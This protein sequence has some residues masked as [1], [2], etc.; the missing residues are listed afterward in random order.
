MV[1]ITHR[2]PCRSHPFGAFQGRCY[3]HDAEKR[4]NALGDQYVLPCRKEF[5]IER[6][7]ADADAIQL[8]IE[9][10]LR[11]PLYPDRVGPK[12]H[13][14]DAHS[15]QRFE[16]DLS[17]EIIRRVA[18]DGCGEA[19]GEEASRPTT[20][21]PPVPPA[22]GAARQEELVPESRQVMPAPPLPPPAGAARPEQLVPEGLPTC[23]CGIAHPALTCEAW[24][25]ILQASL[26][27]AGGALVP[28]VPGPAANHRRCELDGVVLRDVP[29]DGHCMFHAFSSE[30]DRLYGKSFARDG[31][32]V[33][34]APDRGYL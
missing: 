18:P 14:K 2:K 7:G 27:V 13:Q 30:L 21:A 5:R 6:E 31:G 11:A 10:L 8:C 12:G 16:A 34:N 9:W 29:G 23:C 24:Q 17:Q 3:H 32:G 15:D 1:T 25:A 19:A 4:A 26:R 33:T 22:A 28:A 20:P